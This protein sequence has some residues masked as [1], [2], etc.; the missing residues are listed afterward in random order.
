MLSPEKI[1]EYRQMSIS[2]RLR[3][4]LDMC[5][6]STRFLLSGTPEQI[7]KKFAL[8]RRENDLRNENMLRA[9]ARTSERRHR[10]CRRS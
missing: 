3:L 9:I 8:I 1:H 6:D 5:R 4:V 10:E 7:A 2:E